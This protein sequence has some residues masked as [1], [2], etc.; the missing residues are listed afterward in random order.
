MTA[1]KRE[2]FRNWKRRVLSIFE[3]E[4]KAPLEVTELDEEQMLIGFE[5]G[6]TPQEYFDE[7]LANINEQEE[8]FVARWEL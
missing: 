7:H 1:G 2:R 6:D 8:R 3:F 4:F 5:D